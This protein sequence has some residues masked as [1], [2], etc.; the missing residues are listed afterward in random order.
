MKNIKIGWRLT[1]AFSVILALLVASIVIS[2]VRLEAVGKIT[3]R[4]ANESMSRE[5]NANELYRRI[6]GNIIRIVAAAKNADPVQ[7]KY[8]K[9]QISQRIE[10]NTKLIELILKTFS[11]VESKAVLDDIALNRKAIL[12]TN[13]DIFVE[14]GGGREAQALA[15]VDSHLI[16]EGDA[17]LKNIRKL[18]DIQRKNIDD[19]FKEVDNS[20]SSAVFLLGVLGLAAVIVGIGLSA[21]VTRSITDPLKAAV[22]AA[23]RVAEGDFSLEFAAPSRDE[24][25]QLLAALEKMTGSLSAMALQIRDV[26]SF[27]EHAAEQIA[28]RN[29]DLQ[30]RIELQA[31]S[32]E[33]TASSMEQLT[34]TVKQ[35]A[36]SS[37]EANGYAQ[38]ASQVASAGGQAVQ[39]VV[40]T[41]GE[42]SHSSQ[43]IA[44]IIGVIEAI[45]F[46][47]NILALNAAVEAARAGE[48]GRGFAVVATEVRNLA[49][50][51]SSAAKDI[52][53]LIDA[54][55]GRVNA[56]S[57]LVGRT[58]N[59]IMGVVTSVQK[60]GVV[61]SDISAASKEQSIGLGE[62]NQAIAQMD[63]ST[64]ENAALIEAASAEAKVLQQNA[65]RLRD[66]VSVFKVRPSMSEDEF[67][68]LSM[69]S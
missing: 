69:P 59:E 26:A 1:L 3:D 61:I 39:Q 32:L 53:Q 25:G 2:V 36:D 19:L 49:H 34:V 66:A 64:Q 16:P 20:Y 5:R 43:E 13:A 14:K 18:A 50:R 17:Y 23:N 31:S 7:Q 27:V 22:V 47:T 15:L 55:V 12:K 68:R 9:D 11:D 8:Y 41:M 35:N 51:S 57:E 67:M 40:S 21:L 44:E 42:I 33:E 28:Q 65:L 30:G 6:E 62:I 4:M 45:A 60:V 37:R 63:K 29:L 52:K 48:Q 10:E 24:P 38:S 58:G 46:Q 54:S 56:G